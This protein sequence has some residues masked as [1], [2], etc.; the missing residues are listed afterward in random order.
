M[1]NEL[2]DSRFN[3]VTCC[4]EQRAF[5]KDVIKR[6]VPL[7]WPCGE[8][9]LERALSPVWQRGAGYLKPHRTASL[10]AHEVRSSGFG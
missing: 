4:P 7:L 6:R 5:V 9:E 1:V 8:D 10:T 3:E 2:I